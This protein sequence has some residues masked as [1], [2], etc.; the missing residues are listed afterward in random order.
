MLSAGSSNEPS[1]PQ[2]VSIRQDAKVWL[3]KR[4]SV[5][6]GPLYTSKLYSPEH[7]WTGA[8]AWWIQIPLARL[9]T[10]EFIEVL[11]E[12]AGKDGDYVHLTVPTAFLDDRRHALGYIGERAINLFLSAE[13]DRFLTDL[14]G[15]GRIDFSAFQNRN[16]R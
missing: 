13:P 9:E 1:T 14:C 10:D 2:Y 15:T 16:K 5:L 12:S 6:R 3:A 11:C 8:D 7:S 4:G